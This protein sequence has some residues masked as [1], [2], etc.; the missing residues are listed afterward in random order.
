MPVE[1]VQS[2]AFFVKQALEDRV[3]LM[4]LAPAAKAPGDNGLVC[5]RDHRNAVGVE[6]PDSFGG[7]WKQAYMIR[8][9]KQM[10]FL[11]RD[12]VTVYEHGD[13]PRPAPPNGA[14]FHPLLGGTAAPQPS[15]RLLPRDD[16]A[17]AA[18]SG[19]H[20]ALINWVRRL[21]RIRHDAQ[22]NTDAQP[23]SAAQ[24]QRNGELKLAAA[25]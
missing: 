23:R 11:V 8:P 20:W 22:D 16:V 14:R 1:C 5:D 9:V 12:A 4:Q 3:N 18:V 2:S 21:R 25:H 19:S 15:S 17:L 13:P 6:P 24:P 10:H 7:A